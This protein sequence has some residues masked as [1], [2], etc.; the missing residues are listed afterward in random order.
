[1]RIRENRFRARIFNA[2]GTGSLR[3]PMRL[4]IWLIGALSLPLFPAIAAAATQVASPALG[5]GIASVTLLAMIAL[6]AIMWRR[7][8]RQIKRSTR[9]GW[10][11]WR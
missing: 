10:E 7:F 5:I 8:A 9:P 6:V 2:R 4:L 1:M 11:D 3:R